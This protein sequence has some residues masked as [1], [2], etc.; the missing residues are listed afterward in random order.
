MLYR[1]VF[2]E[3]IGLAGIDFVKPLE[4]WYPPFGII[5]AHKIKTEVRPKKKLLSREFNRDSG[6]VEWNLAMAT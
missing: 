2:I 3:K 4:K 1:P 6:C 5:C